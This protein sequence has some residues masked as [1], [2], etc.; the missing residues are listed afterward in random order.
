MGV[1][2]A[3]KGLGSV[4]VKTKPLHFLSIQAAKGQAALWLFP[5]LNLRSILASRLNSCSPLGVGVEEQHGVEVGQLD[6]VRHEL[7]SCWVA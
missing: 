5:N 1:P 3:Y 7:D 2:F 6:G 4:I